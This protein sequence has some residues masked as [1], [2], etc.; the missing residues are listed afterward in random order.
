[1]QSTQ[2]L[3]SLKKTKPRLLDESSQDKGKKKRE[4]ICRPLL[5]KSKQTSFQTTIKK[6]KNQELV[7]C[8]LT[9]AKYYPGVIDYLIRMKWS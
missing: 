4:R 8:Q 7:V 2:F 6:K 3:G 9:S 5:R 1:M